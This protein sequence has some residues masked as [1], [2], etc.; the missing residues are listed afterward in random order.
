MLCT[1]RIH[2]AQSIHIQHHNAYLQLQGLHIMHDAKMAHYLG[3]ECQD[4]VI[5]KVDFIKQSLHMWLD[6]Q[7]ASSYAQELKFIL[8]LIVI[9]T[10]VHYP[11]TITKLV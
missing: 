9:A 5:T 1:H 4:T 10:L 8:L 2:P 3:Q 7:K 11:D 6:L